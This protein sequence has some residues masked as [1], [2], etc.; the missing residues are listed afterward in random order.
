MA[1]TEIRNA[2]AL[3]AK[4]SETHPSK[5]GTSNARLTTD[6]HVPVWA[7]IGHLEVVEGN[8]DQVA[9]DYGIPRKAVD[10]ALA[11]LRTAQSIH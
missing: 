7:F 9:H 6:R 1:T 11:Y 5:P 10:A 2:D 8:A 4:Y 3:I